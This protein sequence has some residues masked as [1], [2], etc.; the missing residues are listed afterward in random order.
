MPDYTGPLLYGR[1]GDEYLVTDPISAV[2]SYID[3]VD[4]EDREPFDILEHT[5]KKLGAFL[6][7]GADVLGRE[8]ER[9]CEGY[10]DEV[11]TE[12]CAEDFERAAEFPDVIA[13]FQ[14]AVDLWGWHCRYPMADK[15][16]RTIKV[17]F[18]EDGQPLMDGEHQ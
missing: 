13:A 7:S 10:V 15:V 14:A 16:I 9:M 1:D 18:T 17:T 6:P 5:S 2:Q 3:D 4:P 11:S 12:E 8:C